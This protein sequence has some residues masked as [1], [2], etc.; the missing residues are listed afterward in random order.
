MGSGTDSVLTPGAAGESKTTHTSHKTSRT[1]STISSQELTLFI[2][3]EHMKK[4]GSHAAQEP[5]YRP[6]YLQS[7]FSLQ[8]CLA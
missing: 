5:V 2:S 8:T 6:V 4:L 1:V 3:S 7:L